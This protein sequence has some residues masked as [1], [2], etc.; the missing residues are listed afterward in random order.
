MKG[1]KIMFLVL[2]VT[3]AIASAWEKVPAIKDG[4]HA[5]LDPSAGALLNWNITIGMLVIVFLF[6]LA[7]TLAQKYGTNQEEL[8]KLKEEQKLLQ[9][10]I[11]KYRDHPEKML[12]LNKKQLEFLPKT[13]DLTTKPLIYTAI[14]FVL[15]F[16]WFNDYFSNPLLDGFKFWGIFNW[17]WFYFVFAIVFSTILRKALKVY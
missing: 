17:F 10:E 5:I 12:E 11:K 14:P 1:M 2:I 13:M 7:T 4:A 16:R 9:Q 8:K 3:F 6:T 15:F